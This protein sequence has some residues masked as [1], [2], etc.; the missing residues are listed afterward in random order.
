MPL[1][2][3]HLVGD[4]EQQRRDFKAKRFC[5]LDVDHEFEFC[6]LLDG[7]V[8]WLCAFQD[9]VDN[10]RRAPEDL[11][12]VRSVRNQSAGFYEIPA[13]VNRRKSKLCSEIDDF[14]P[15]AGEE[16]VF[17][18][19][20]TGCASSDRSLKTTGELIGGSH[21]EHFEHLLL[22]T[23]FPTWTRR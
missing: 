2:F 6:R 4:R 20:Q 9:F 7:N 21:F 14:P 11:S 12:H 15:K 22:T 19:D 1:L 23:E 18:C 16:G 13:S 8:P 17:Y 10:L 5:G 3:D